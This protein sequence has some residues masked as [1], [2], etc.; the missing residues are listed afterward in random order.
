[1]AENGKTMHDDEPE[2]TNEK[3]KPI[4]GISKDTVHQLCSGQVVL[5]LAVAVKELVENSIDAGATL[6]EVKLHNQ[7]LDS[8]DVSDN[9]CGVEESNIE[10]MTA[11]YHTSKLREFVD[12]QGV[13]T[14]GFRGEALSSLCSLSDMVVV[15]RHSSTNVGLRVE[16][17]HEGKIKKKT[18]CA[19]QV[20]TTVTLS[21]LF[22]TL[23][24]RKRE[25]VRNIKKEFSKMCQI[26]QGY[27]L[28]SKGVRIICTNVNAKGFKSVILA[29]HGSQNYVDN[30]HAVFG[31]KQVSDLVQ[32]KS[33]FEENQLT[34]ESFQDLNET[35]SSFQITEDDIELIN[36]KQFELQG[37]ISSCDHGKGRG[38]KDR[39]YFFVNS[40]P[41]EPQNVAKVVNQIYHRYN[42]HQY[43][44][45]FL[46]VITERSQVDVNLTPDKRQLLVNNEK[47]LLLAVK[48]ALLNTFGNIPSTLKMKNTTIDT[49]FKLKTNDSTTT[50]VDS[51]NEEIVPANKPAFLQVLSQWKSTGDI[52]GPLKNKGCKR[53]PVNEIAM[54]TAKMKKIQQYLSNNDSLKQ[55]EFNNSV[56][57]YKSDSDSDK[58]GDVSIFDGEKLKKESKG[59]FFCYILKLELK[60]FLFFL[61]FDILLQN[62]SLQEQDELVEKVVC[63]TITVP[64]VKFFEQKPTTNNCDDDDNESF[65]ESENN[66]KD[67]I[68][69]S[70]EREEEEVEKED[71]REIIENKTVVLDES[72]DEECEVSYLPCGKIQTSIDEIRAAV[73][74]END[75]ETEMLE[76]KLNRLKFKSKID[77]N[78]NKSAEEE[79]Q[80]EISKDMFA[81]MEIIG[82]FN[83]GFIVVKL[84][85]DLLIVDQH[86]SDEKYNFEQ[87][88][89]STTLQ[90][91]QLAVPQ[92]LEM[93]ADNEMVLMDNLH[94]FEKNGF[95]FQIDEDGPPTNRVKLLGKPYSKQWEFGKDDIDELIFML[96]DAPKGSLCRPSRIRAMFA[97]RACR[98]SVMIGTALNQSKMRTLI[99]HMGELDQPWNCPHGRP[100]M[101][102]LINTDMLLESKENEEDDEDENNDNASKN[103]DSS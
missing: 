98:K 40:R 46:N 31:A 47:I 56:A 69:D 12:L 86:A 84:G 2:A 14:F 13:E 21:N 30:I 53:K 95:K 72:D 19:R 100:T 65:K 27:C 66:I 63:K 3:A 16:L 29:T 54:R 64:N 20:G 58:D 43:P 80:L 28:V 38:S 68:N 44:F 57:S 59:K 60:D 93:T 81:K 92:R 55:Q 4:K 102:H 88:Q 78:Q 91:Q 8:V 11:K 32:I 22:S 48:K 97:S 41:C 10:A 15:T 83:L 89:K 99:D 9:G 71:F 70:I 42:L 18:P 37:W 52:D 34:M 23:P 79:L 77:P 26:L 103:S 36:A 45:I 74:L 67:E 73:Q 51:G 25:F 1:M 76:K 6:V 94:V 85:S 96:K 5:S 35:D 7:G 17:D 90:Y 82:Q 61:E 101:R 39:Q 50:D 24:V 33:P 75:L 87:L 62:Q 49:L